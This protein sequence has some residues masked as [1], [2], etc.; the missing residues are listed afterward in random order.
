[1]RIYTLG[2]VYRG[3]ERWPFFDDADVYEVDRYS[4]HQHQGKLPFGSCF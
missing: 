1:M 2:S 3:R 4:F